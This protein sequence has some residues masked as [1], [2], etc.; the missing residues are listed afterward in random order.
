MVSFL[1]FILIYFARQPESF[2]AHKPP[3]NNARSGRCEQCY[4]SKRLTVKAYL[5][6]FMD[7]KVPMYHSITFDIMYCKL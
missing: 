1:V 2:I 4:Q 3:V 5:L 6:C 7:E